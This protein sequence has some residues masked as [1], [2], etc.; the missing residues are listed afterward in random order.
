MTF[1]VGAVKEIN[2]FSNDLAYLGWLG[3]SVNIGN[4]TNAPA[5]RAIAEL[6]ENYVKLYVDYNFGQGR[7]Y[8][9]FMRYKGIERADEELYD[10][11]ILNDYQGSLWNLF[12]EL[13]N[14]PFNEMF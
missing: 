6:I 14:A 7:T 2:L 13:Q 1:E 5:A 10:S 12:K 3:D 4:I 11:S 9:S 8:N